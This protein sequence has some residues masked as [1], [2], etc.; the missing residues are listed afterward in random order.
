M[1][2]VIKMTPLQ[3]KSLC[4]Q[5]I[6]PKAWSGGKFR[7]ILNNKESPNDNPWTQYPQSTSA[8]VQKSNTYTKLCV[9]PPNTYSSCTKK[10]QLCNF[11]IGNSRKTLPDGSLKIADWLVTI[12]LWLTTWPIPSTVKIF[13]YVQALKQTL[14][15]SAFRKANYSIE[16]IDL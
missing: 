3:S 6:T 15:T 5:D 7:W 1:Q 4:E 2:N 13:W 8:M 11:L 14:T 12:R 16:L 9:T 10:Q